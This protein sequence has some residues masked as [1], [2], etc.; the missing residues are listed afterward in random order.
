MSRIALMAALS[1]LAIATQAA[2]DSGLR[3]DLERIA[4][5]RIYFAHQS[6]G[7]NLIEGVREL[8]GQEGVALRIAETPQASAVAPA[9]FGHTFVPENGEPLKKL[10]SFRAELGSA[11][12]DI[13]LLKFCY[14]DITADT[15]VNAL[16][17]RYQATIA[18]LRGKNPRTTFVHV[19]L[20][21]TEVQTGPKALAKRM[22]GRAPYGTIENVRREQ[23]NELLRKA[24]AGRE[25]VFD[26]ARVES[27]APDG[28]LV[29]VSWQGT[30]APA[31]APAYSDDGGH[32]NARGRL[33][34]ARELVAVLAAAKTPQP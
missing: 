5:E 21:L 20:P 8:A 1:S 7:A 4:R 6:V 24:Y 11:S 14:V 13:A 16:F 27:T 2:A 26:L 30:V 23:Y 22:L 12:V 34:A 32:L 10:E 25:P 31:M 9:T 28:T 15:D 18:E 3:T 17:A 29:K 33:R 19:T